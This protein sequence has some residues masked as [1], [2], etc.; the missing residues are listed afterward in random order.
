MDVAVITNP[1]VDGLLTPANNTVQ[2]ALQIDNQAID[3]M[4]IVFIENGVLNQQQ[5][6]LKLVARRFEGIL[7]LT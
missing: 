5:I 3:K 4:Q 1:Q 6:R 2:L 7:Q